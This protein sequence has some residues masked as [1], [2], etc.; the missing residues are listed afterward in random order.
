[1]KLTGTVNIIPV[2]GGIDL[3][4]PQPFDW[5]S[6]GFVVGQPVTISGFSETFTITGFG[7]DNPLD[8]VVNTIMHLNGTPTAAELAA[9][10]PDVTF[11]TTT[12]VTL[13]GSGTSGTVH[14]TTGDWIADD[15]LVGQ[16]ITISGLTGT[17]KITAITNGNKDLHVTGS[18]AAFTGTASRTVSAVVR[19]V[20]GQ[21]TPV[22]SQTIPITIAPNAQ[23]DGGT[24]TRNDAGSFLADG[25]VVGQLV[26]IENV[27]GSWR[28]IGVTA[29]ALTLARGDKLTAQSL[30]T[31]VL[32]PGPHGGLTVVHGGGNQPLET[33]FA[34][35]LERNRPDARNDGL[36]SA[37]NQATT[38]ATVRGRA[39]TSILRSGNL[40]D[41]PDDR[42]LRDTAVPV[43][44]S[45][46]RLRHRQ[47]DEPEQL[48]PARDLQLPPCRPAEAGPD[49]GSMTITVQDP[50]DRGRPADD[51]TLSLLLRRAPS[52]PSGFKD[53]IAGDHLSEPRRR[54]HDQVPHAETSITLWNAALTPTRTG[55]GCAPAR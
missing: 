8:T 21:D 54:V 10:P 15:F 14:R 23:N 4:R 37:D 17:W 24:V 49:V 16:T 2:A 20:I 30:T 51:S 5:K 32:V 1:M 25:F 6:Q 18:T 31:T 13:S 45:V 41:D 46:P 7:D 11:S 27:T 47:R 3:T 44:G 12:A 40:R 34:M 52:R 9:A 43:R 53:G 19:T 26:M 28:L 35:T 39:D 48:D 36:S 22:W 33:D 42:E 29:R 50:A 38:P 55:L